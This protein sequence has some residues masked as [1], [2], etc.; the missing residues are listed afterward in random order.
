MKRAFLLFCIGW[1]LALPCAN[2]QGKPAS[3]VGITKI[4]IAKRQ[5][6]FGGASFGSTGP[7]EFLTGTAYGELDPKAPMNAGIVDLQYAPVNSRGHVEYSMDI[8]ILKPVDI[9]KGNGRLVYDVLNRGHEKAL[10]DMNLSENHSTPPAAVSDPATA[11]LMKRGYTVAWS[12]WE[13]EDSAETSKPG[14]LKAKFP[15]AM[16]DG[17]PITAITREELT[18]VPP[19]PVFTVALTYPASNTDPSAATLTVR[20]REGDPRKPVAA[21]SWS[22]ADPRHLRITTPPG[23]D[24]EALYEFIYPATG[25]VVEGIA[26]ASIRDFVLFLRYAETDSAGQPN[27]VHPATPYKAVL[28][29][30]VSQSGRLLKDMVYQDFNIDDSGRIVFDGMFALVS[31][32]RKTFTNAEF[33]QPGRFT[34]QHEDHLFQGADFPFTYAATTDPSSSKT[35]GILVKCTKSHSCPKIFHLDTDTEMWQGRASLVVTSPS[36]KAVPIPDN[37]RV[38]IPGVPHESNDIVGS[39]LGTPERGVC[40]ELK[41]QLPYRYYARALFLALDQWVTEGVEPPPSRYPNLKDGTLVTMAE[42]AKLWP[43]IPGVPFSPNINRIWPLDYS[44]QPPTAS[45]PEY[46]IF[47]ERT[48]AD[49]NPIGGIEPPEIAA[50]T[51]TYSGRNTRAQGFAEGDLCA[52]YGS[53]IP[54][55][56]TRKERLANHDSR[57]SLEERYKS[58]EDFTAKR[59]Q[60]AG[61]LVRERL[62]LPEDAA[63]ISAETLPIRTQTA[64]TKP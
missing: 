4:V 34:R 40:K 8:T 49:G 52:L 46:P 33:A 60:A 57:L 31:G 32:S 9:N 64:E 20:E 58:Q 18:T 44:H 38:Y 22:Y 17:K 50:P 37:V 7:Y 62:L 10:S 56:G 21:S 47:V 14:L 11:L 35:D 54:F 15:I 55:A 19:T 36:G 41:N 28:G 30:G 26:F 63:T 48:N 13:A 12:A 27:P 3:G 45:G 1:I 53:Y 43:D 23:M 59:K 6:A 51:G 25:A 5:P 29:L 42:A 16:R 2:G 61:R 39:T 24:T